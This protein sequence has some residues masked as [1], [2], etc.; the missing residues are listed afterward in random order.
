[1]NWEAIGAIGQAVSA[2][3]LIVVIVQVRHARAETRRSMSQGRAAAVRELCMHRSG[4]E[5]LN[6]ANRKAFVALG[7]QDRPFAKGQVSFLLENLRRDAV[8]R[9][10]A[11]CSVN[12][13]SSSFLRSTI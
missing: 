4:N 12:C 9:F 11:V 13:S 7:G 6:T 10:G 2:L 1:M 8:V 5:H 3:A